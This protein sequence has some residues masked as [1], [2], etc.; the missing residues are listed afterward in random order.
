MPPASDLATQFFAFYEMALIDPIFQEHMHINVRFQDDKLGLWKVKKDSPTT[1]STYKS[2]VNTTSKLDWQFDH[3]SDSV[4]FMDLF[5]WIDR[6]T[7]TLKWK[8]HTKPMS[9]DLLLG[10]TS[11]H[12]PGVHKGIIISRVETLYRHCSERTNYINEIDQFY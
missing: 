5:V 12:P 6:C 2:S 7:C 10:P 9:L 3:L 11:A 4:I 1:Y 8:H